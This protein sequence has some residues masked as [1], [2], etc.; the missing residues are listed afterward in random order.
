[1]IKVSINVKKKKSLVFKLYF[2][3]M[4]CD[5]NLNLIIIEFK[6]DD[7]VKLKFVNLWDLSGHSERTTSRRPTCQ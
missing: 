4:S 1:M 7:V 2:H 3:K 6:S 5:L